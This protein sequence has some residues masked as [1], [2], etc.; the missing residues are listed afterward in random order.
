[1]PRTTLILSSALAGTVLAG[2]FLYDWSAL[3]SGTAEIRPAIRSASAVDKSWQSREPI[4]P[5]PQSVVTDPRKVALGKRLFHDPRLSKDKNVSCASCHNLAEGGADGR[6]TSVGIGNAVGKRNAPTVLNSHFNLAQFWDGRAKTLEEQVSGPMQDPSEMGATLSMVLDRLRGDRSYLEAFR[7]IYDDGVQIANVENAVAEF[8]RSLITPNARFDRYLR[9]DT[10]A[11]TA[12]EK[13]GYALFKNLGC[14]S[15]HQG[16]NVGGNLFQRLGIVVDYVPEHGTAEKADFGRFNVTGK[17][18][19]RFVFKVPGLRNVELTAPY[20][21][22]GSAADLETVV[23]IMAR[24]Q[25]GRQLSVEQVD[26]IVSF[27]KTLTGEQPEV[28]RP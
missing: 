26:D 25:I 5:I 14:A 18:E 28:D 11:L 21:H 12:S 9:G 1:M 16:V 4:L 2:S 6:A 8:E 19:D 27:L 3:R 23:T 17:E 7:K 13:N 15:C 20:L 22:D 10:E 24:Y